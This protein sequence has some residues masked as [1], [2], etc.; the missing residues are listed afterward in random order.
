MWGRMMYKKTFFDGNGLPRY[1]QNKI[2]PLDLHCSAQG[3]IT[4]LKFKKYDIEA[5]DM[6]KKIA[7]WAIGNMWDDEEG[8]FYFQKTK[9]FT[10]KTPYLRWPNAWMFCA[11]A[12]LALHGAKS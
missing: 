6:A 5:V 9:Y 8:Y 2:Y 11:L 4:F 7:H 10:N 1:S 12:Q 3:I